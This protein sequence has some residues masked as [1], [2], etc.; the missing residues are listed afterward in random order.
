MDRALLLLVTVKI[1]CHISCEGESI[2]DE[3]IEGASIEGDSHITSIHA[4]QCQDSH[5]K[6]DFS[7]TNGGKEV[8]NHIVRYH[9]IVN[10]AINKPIRDV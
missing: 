2:E 8:I 6:H 10:S 5:K 7:I 9:L 1:T 3:P 4:I